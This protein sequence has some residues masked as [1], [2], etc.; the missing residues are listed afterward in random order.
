MPD[1][2]QLK[3]EYEALQKQV[4]EFG[5]A[6][7]RV[8]SDGKDLPEAKRRLKELRV[9]VDAMMERITVVRFADEY[10]SETGR[11]EKVEID[12]EKIMA[13]WKQFY[14]DHGID[15][16][17]LPGKIKVDGKVKRAMQELIRQF[18]FNWVIVIPE[19]L[20]LDPELEEVADERHPSISYCP[21]IRIKTS[22]DNRYDELH[23]KMTVG[24]LKTRANWGRLDNDGFQG[25]CDKRTGVRLIFTRRDKELNGNALF[26]ETLGQSDAQLVAWLKS[27][28]T[29]NGI[30]LGKF[31]LSPLTVSEFLVAQRDYHVE[32]AAAGRKDKYLDE[33][34][35]CQL[36]MTEKVFRKA[37]DSIVA[38]HVNFHLPNLPNQPDQR[39]LHLMNCD[40]A[41]GDPIVGSRLARSF[42]VKSGVARRD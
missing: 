34:F 37:D 24:F 4:A 13:H 36:G 32:E 29:K 28:Q 14:T 15:W 20:V 7:E 1:C 10:V 40:R 12:L 17:W 8:K 6:V 3:H 9:A 41:A 18:G 2:K 16:P 11:R 39:Q 22:S 19:A 33:D 38:R 26:A 30:K 42:A 31:N 5:L 25:L 21:D 35:F 27:G 23:D